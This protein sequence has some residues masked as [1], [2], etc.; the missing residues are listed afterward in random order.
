MPATARLYTCRPP[1]ILR[2]PVCLLLP[3]PADSDDDVGSGSSEEGAY[4][5][6]D[7]FIVCQPD[8]DYPALLHRRFKYHTR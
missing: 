1:G 2:G 6:L 5:D 4:S 3:P 8:R 7:D